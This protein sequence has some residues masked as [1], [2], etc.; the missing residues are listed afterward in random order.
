MTSELLKGLNQH[1]TLEFRAAHEYLAMAIWLAEHDLPGFAKW[2][3]QQS[4][5]ERM[6][7][8]RI[9]DHLVERDQKVKL[10]AVAAPPMDWKSAEALCTHVLKNEQ[11]VT[12]SI[13]NL[14]AMAEKAKDRPATIML[15]WFV[16][17]QM[18]E[19]AAARAVLGRIR[20]AGNTG[21][22]LLMID[23]ELAGGTMPGMPAE[24]ADTA[25]N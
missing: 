6:H 9:I 13:N 2:M 8:Q 20:L 17:E 12:A 22:G 19:E 16:N 18:E 7:A 5:D 15:Q 23:Q 21:V 11:D 4:S 25:G 14:Y 10:P 1:L 24:P 3:T